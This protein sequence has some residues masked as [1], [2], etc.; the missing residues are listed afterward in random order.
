[1]ELVFAGKAEILLNGR[2]VIRSASTEFEIPSVIRLGYMVK[3]PRQQITLTK[4]E[5][6]RRDDYICQYCGQKASVLT[7]DHVIPRRL[8]GQH[9][10]TNV[11]AACPPCNRRKGGKTVDQANM[12]LRRLPFEPNPSAYYR[13]SR[14]LTTHEEWEQFIQGW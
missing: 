7:V 10:W 8:G 5:I 12:R 6:L 3:R 11:V 2:G 4:R 14:H 9:I 13:F 1:M